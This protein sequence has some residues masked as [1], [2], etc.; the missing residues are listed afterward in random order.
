[1]SSISGTLRNHRR[2]TTGLNDEPIRRLRVPLLA[3]TEQLPR[4]RHDTVLRREGT[5][6]SI[7]HCAVPD[8]PSTCTVLGVR[9]D[10]AVGALRHLGGLQAQVVRSLWRGRNPKGDDARRHHLQP[11]EAVST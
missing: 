1:M 8:V 11:G 10:V 6:I 3:P 5:P 9:P 2:Q 7:G 4:S